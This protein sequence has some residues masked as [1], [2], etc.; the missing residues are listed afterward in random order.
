MFGEN[1]EFKIEKEVVPKKKSIQKDFIIFI[2]QIKQDEVLSS[3]TE[4]I[5][6]KV[7]DVCRLIEKENYPD[8]DG[9]LTNTKYNNKRKYPDDK[10]RALVSHFNSP[11]L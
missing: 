3:A 7:D 11:R 9:V 6:E 1:T 10:L 5:G 2:F 4:N 8:L